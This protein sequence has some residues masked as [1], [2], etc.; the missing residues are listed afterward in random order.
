MTLAVLDTNV[1]VQAL[2]SSP[3]SASARVLDAYFDGRF[4]LAYAPET[5]AELVEV[6]SIP[7]IRV[8][9]KFSDDEVLEFVAA[10]LAEATEYPDLS[11]DSAVDKTARDLTDAKFLALARL[12]NADYLVTNDRRHLV[13]LR[14][15]GRTQILTP[16]KF[17]RK[18]PE[19]RI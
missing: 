12:S 9:H 13:P 2:V 6:L 19:D 1:V 8:R 7:R 11:A 5:I 15:L 14:H 3:R 16:A 10:L 4:Q 17:L 18:L